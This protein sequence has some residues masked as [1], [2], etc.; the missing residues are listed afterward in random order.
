M[1]KHMATC[2]IF[3]D[4]FNFYISPKY[5]VNTMS[6]CFCLSLWC[7]LVFAV[8]VSVPSVPFLC[9]FKASSSSSGKDRGVWR[10]RERV[11]GGGLKTPTRRTASSNPTPSS[12]SSPP[13]RPPPRSRRKSKSPSSR[14][15]HPA[16]KQALDVDKIGGGSN[17]EDFRKTHKGSRDLGGVHFSELDRKWEGVALE[18][19]CRGSRM[20]SAVYQTSD[21]PS[22]VKAK[23]QMDEAYG[24]GQIDRSK[25]KATFV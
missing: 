8:P 18:L 25:L 3:I 12:P 11:G 9:V 16:P 10:G 5:L 6:F 19:Q 14:S 1:F 4:I 20:R 23:K 13:P 2:L 7:L 22:M 15:R 24:R 17:S 21:L